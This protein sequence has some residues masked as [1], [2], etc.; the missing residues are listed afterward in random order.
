M[1]TGPAVL[2]RRIHRLQKIDYLSQSIDRRIPQQV[3]HTLPCRQKA[4]IAH[5]ES[6]SFLWCAVQPED[7]LNIEKIALAS[8]V[9]AAS[10]MDSQERYEASQPL[11]PA[12]PFDI[13]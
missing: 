5:L 12:S 4:V 10:L 2:I 11:V 8:T 1:R 9:T 7:S 6:E 3:Q 13:Q